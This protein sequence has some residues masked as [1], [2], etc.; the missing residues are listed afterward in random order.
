MRKDIE[1]NNELAA[2]NDIGSGQKRNLCRNCVLVV[3][4]AVGVLIL[5]VYF[6]F[7]SGFDK[8]DSN[9]H[10]NIRNNDANEKI[11]TA[12]DMVEFDNNKEDGHQKNHTSIVNLKPEELEKIMEIRR[13]QTRTKQKAIYDHWNE[14]HPGESF[15]VGNTWMKNLNDPSKLPNHSQT[16]NQKDTDETSKNIVEVVSVHRNHE[17]EGGA[18][19]K[20]DSQEVFEE[21]QV[22]DDSVENLEDEPN[23]TKDTIDIDKEAKPFN[24]ISDQDLTYDDDLQDV[25]AWYA[26]NVTIESGVMYE[27]IE[28]MKHDKEAFTQGLTYANGKIYE[29][30]GLYHHSSVRILNPK[31]GEV[32]QKVDGD[33]SIFGE[34]MTFYDNKL[35]QIVWKAAHGYVYD[36]DNISAHPIKYNYTTT[37]RNEGWGITYDMDRNEL[38][39]TDGSANLIFWDPECW[40]SGS[41]HPKED[42]PPIQVKRLNGKPARNLNEIEYWRGRIVANVWMTDLLLIIHPETGIVEKEYDFSNIFTKRPIGTDVF[43]GI[44]VSDHPDILYVT[45]KKWDRMFKVKLLCN[46]SPE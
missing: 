33:G 39:V 29:S 11:H 16:V 7:S 26:G 18:E 46:L 41:C 3:F 35:I 43:N 23:T 9:I 24:Q 27:V 31:N 21:S 2:R 32:I 14:T 30:T 4:C 25:N 34:G 38:I 12:V 17:D 15:P 45:G 42:K 36:A 19:Q 37:K 8:F 6:R 22:S 40:K 1:S 5:G 10:K 13:N 44:S 20:P 28:E